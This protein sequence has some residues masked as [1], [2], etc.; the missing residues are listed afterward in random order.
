MKSK[1]VIEVETKNMNEVRENEDGTGEIVTKDIEKELHSEIRDRIKD[2]LE[3][4]GERI[5]GVIEEDVMEF[6]NVVVEGFES[7][8]DFGDIKFK[9][10]KQK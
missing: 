5:Y 8:C 10:K 2:G 3:D 9:V 4:S 1:F 7:F 6:G